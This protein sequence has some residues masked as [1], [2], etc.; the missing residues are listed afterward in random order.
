MSKVTAS[1]R[2]NGDGRSTERPYTGLL[3]SL[4]DNGRHPARHSRASYNRYS[5]IPSRPLP[6]GSDGSDS[7]DPLSDF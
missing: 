5:S 1:S 2:F 7:S 6:D 4:F 3:V